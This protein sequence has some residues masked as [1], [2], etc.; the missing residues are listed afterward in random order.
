MSKPVLPEA[1]PSAIGV[2]PKPP[3][4]RLPDPDAIFRRRAARY[5]KLAD[6]HEL[7]PFLRFLA[8]LAE[9]QHAAGEGLDPPAMP[10]PEALERAHRHAMPPLDRAG[11]VP[12]PET[13]VLIDRLLAALDGLEM[14][15]NARA[16]VERVR[17]AGEAERGEM[18]AN[19]LGDAV[20]FEAVAE[21]ALVA[22]AMQVH[23]ARAAAALDAGRL[24]AVGDGVCPA[25]GG[26]PSASLVVGW[27]RNPGT[28]FCSCSTC[29]TLWNYVRAKCTLCGSTAKVS[30]REIDGAGGLVKAE[31]CETCHGYV[32]VL[33][34]EREPELDPI[35]D[36]VAT[37]GLDLLVKELG[38]RRGAVNPFLIG[39]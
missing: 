3:F 17:G 36:D 25:C 28:R 12:G 37:L 11:F 38:F 34:Q 14:P 19:V 13:M 18:I 24:Q 35:A 7:A 2:I 27:T 29:G 32:K 30:F 20:P 1:D 21:H 4:A 39:Y 8:G 15:P 6:G 9:A 26:P 10:A 33:Y 5:R 31:V 22:A 16:A 23:F